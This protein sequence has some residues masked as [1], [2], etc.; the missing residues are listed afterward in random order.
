MKQVAFHFILEGWR[1]ESYLEISKDQKVYIYEGNG[2]KFN[3][4]TG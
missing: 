4:A 1:R 3:V 2:K